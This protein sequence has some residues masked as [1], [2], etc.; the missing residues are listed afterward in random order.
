[1]AYIRATYAPLD[2]LSRD[3][4]QPKQMESNPMS[5]SLKVQIAKIKAFD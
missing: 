2:I 4:M 1:M 3:E 5:R